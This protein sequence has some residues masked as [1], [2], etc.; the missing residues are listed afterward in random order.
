MKIDAYIQARMDSKRLSG[1]MMLEIGGETILQRVI[2][3][4]QNVCLPYDGDIVL[5]TTDR[6]EDDILCDIAR[7]NNIGVVREYFPID[8]YLSACIKYEPNWFFRV[9][10]DSPFIDSMVYRM[11][12]LYA[13]CNDGSHDYFAF[14]DGEQKR[15]SASGRYPEIIRCKSFIDYVAS[16][17]DHV[18]I[19]MYGGN[20]GRCGWILAP[21]SKRIAIDTQ[22]DYDAICRVID[23]LGYIPD[24]FEVPY[25]N[26]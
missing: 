14:T 8:R 10:G 13:A 9:C 11:L 25:V 2:N 23:E 5:L 19:G 18:T 21:N 22:S 1:K 24:D 6:K 17:D 12:A 3:G 4:I 26:T 16:V 15:P 7:D 20:A